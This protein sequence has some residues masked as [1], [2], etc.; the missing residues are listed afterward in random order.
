MLETTLGLGI[1]TILFVVFIW[2]LP[3]LLILQ[4]GKTS[5]LE[6]MIWVLLLLFFSW[7]SWILYL[8]LAPVG[9]KQT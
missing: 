9:N 5:G 4:S 6:K 1:G 7:F 8:L 3:I 2:L